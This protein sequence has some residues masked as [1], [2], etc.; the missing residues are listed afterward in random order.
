MKQIV[1]GFIFLISTEHAWSEQITLPIGEQTRNSALDLP[2]RGLNKEQL[3]N[4]FGE[5]EKKYPAVG[6]PGISAWAYPE[7]ITY[8]ERE[9][10]LHS[11]V[12]QKSSSEDSE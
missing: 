7:F 2:Q 12:K 1:L 5:P 8:L 9:L 11:V 10:V 6:D 4:Q 3:H